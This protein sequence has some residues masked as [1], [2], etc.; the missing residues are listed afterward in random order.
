M[1]PDKKQVPQFIILGILVLICVGYVSFKVMGS[2]VAG[3]ST[4]AAGKPG[5]GD[6]AA[7][8]SEASASV[9][10]DVTAYSVFPDLRSVPT[11]RDPFAPQPMPGAM[12]GESAEA[13]NPRPINTRPIKVP[14]ID[15]KPFNPFSQLQP[16]TVA[17]QQSSAPEQ[18]R[19]FTVTGVVRGT[20]NVAIIRAG[21]TG[22]YVVKQGQ[23]IDGRYR[24]IAVTNDGA[25]L[26]DGNRRIYVRVGGA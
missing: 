4:P 13:Q 25:V 6:S 20:Q 18:E 2:G 9:T 3:N 14:K 24:V 16:P 17:A 10:P 5:H 12:I 8:S 21:E 1:K 19:K 23:M 15:I 26:A 7:A 11:R 22:R